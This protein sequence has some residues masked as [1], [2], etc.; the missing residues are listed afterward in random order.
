[1]AIDSSIYFK[2]E[3]PDLFG[4]YERGMKLGDLMGERKKKEAINQA[5]KDNLVTNPDGTTSLNQQGLLA[6]IGKAGY[7]QESYALGKQFQQD[8]YAKAE[9]DYKAQTRKN[10]FIA[11]A[12]NIAKQNPNH[13]G[14]IRNDLIKN[15]MISAQDAPEQFDPAFVDSAIARGQSLQE[16]LDNGF[17]QKQFEY[18]Q[19]KDER[20]FDLRKQ[21]LDSRA[22][23]RKSMR[24]EQRF[25]AGL[26]RDEKNQALETPYGRANTVDDAKQ[27]KDAHIAKKSFDNKI[28][29]MIALREK[30]KGGA[31]L[32]REDVERGKQLSK[33]ALLEYKN[34]AKLGVLS[35]SDEDIINAIIPEDPL[36]YNN[37][38]A[39]IQGQDP[40]LNRLKQFKQDSDKDFAGTV[41]T[42]TRSGVQIQPQQSVKPL[43]APKTG[44]TDGD[45]VFLGGD[46][47]NPKSW[48]KK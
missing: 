16:Q 35:K 29:Q 20:D 25:Q 15:G 14:Q 17:K 28:N 47:S 11:S 27:L 34:M 2:Q 43:S 32:N 3:T 46:P 42:R 13:Y 33:D 10:G 24:E 12:L 37:P 36:A 23:D 21:E 40:I 1:M 44:S 7:G 26:A 31:I 38:V 18:G 30:H 6:Q 8:D 4:S 39:A 48:K 5:Y 19:V 22:L 41:Q 45:Y 9:N